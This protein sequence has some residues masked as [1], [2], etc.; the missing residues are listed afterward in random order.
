MDF[1][2]ALDLFKR[3]LATERSRPDVHAAM[4]ALAQ[5]D[6]IGAVS[7]LIEQALARGERIWITAD[8]H[9]GHAN[10][11][12]Y[13]NRPFV[14][15]AQMNEHLVS[16][17][18]KVREDEWLVIVGDLAMGDHEEAMAWIRRI[19]GRKVMVLGNH[20]LKRNGECRYLAERTLDGQRPLFYTVL[21][22]LAWKDALGQSVLVSHYPATVNH[23]AGRL[24]N[25]HGHLHREVLAPTESTHFV[26]VGWDVTQG[27]VC[28]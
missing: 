25:Y 18:R 7:T 15:V 4:L 3:T 28:L 20:D 2:D 10:V 17:T 1:D 13:C 12:Q 6:T 5:S 11:I 14:D 19:P 27:L 26:N 24:V 16:Q 9:L 23:S 21:P 22:F 8:L